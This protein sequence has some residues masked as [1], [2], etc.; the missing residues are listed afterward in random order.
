MNF[1]SFL[2]IIVSMIYVIMGPTCSGKTELANYLIDKLDC[3]AINFDAFQIYKDMNIG[4]AKLSKDDPHYKRYHLLDIRNP[5]QTFSVMEYQELCRKELSNILDKY[6][7]VVLVGGTGLYVRAALFDYSF[8]KEEVPVDEDLNELSN[9]E[10]HKLL[11]ELDIEESKKIHINNRKR[12]LRAISLIRHSNKK[13]TDILESQEHKPIY[14]DVRFIFISPDR[15]ELYA[16]IDKRVLSMMENGL[17]D[18]VK[19]LLSKYQLSLTASQGIGYKE[20][21]EYLQNKTKYTCCVELIQKRTRNYAKRQV[22]FFKNQ[23]VSETYSSI[24]EAM[25]KIGE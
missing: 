11:E 14:K 3:D 13:K 1:T 17:V 18:E 10:L 2:F 9:E 8:E 24:K 15:E 20:V 19:Y 6:K 7:D 21:I 23:F 16:N 4:T 12:L 5:E 25:E 22:T